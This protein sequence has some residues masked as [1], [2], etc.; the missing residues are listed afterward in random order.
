MTKKKTLVKINRKEEVN[1]IPKTVPK[2]GSETKKIENSR[3]IVSSSK[4]SLLFQFFWSILPQS[5]VLYNIFIYTSNIIL[6]LLER[7]DTLIFSCWYKDFGESVHKFFIVKS[8]VQE[9][10]HLL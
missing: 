10:L 9:N 1:R 5:N 4:C 8:R 6:I 2:R 7:S 3:K